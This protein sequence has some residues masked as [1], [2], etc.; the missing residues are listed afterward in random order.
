MTSQSSK[1]VMAD[2]TFSGKTVKK[3]IFPYLLDK[4][5]RTCEQ[6]PLKDSENAKTMNLKIFVTVAL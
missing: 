3:N 1:A 4:T 2:E 6:V 5:A